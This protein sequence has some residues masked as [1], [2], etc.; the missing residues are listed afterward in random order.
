LI[1]DTKAATWPT[2]KSDFTMPCP[3]DL[4]GV[5]KRERVCKLITDEN[6]VEKEESKI[7]VGQGDKAVE[8]NVVR[9]GK[10]WECDPPVGAAVTPTAEE[11]AEY[12]RDPNDG[13]SKQADN[14]IQLP[15][16]SLKKIIE[17]GG[18]DYLFKCRRNSDGT[19]SCDAKAYMPNDKV[20]K[21]TI[22]RCDKQT[23]PEQYVTN[24]IL[25]TEVDGAPWLTACEPI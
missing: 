21:D 17:E 6:S 3:S 23:V 9:T 22:M 18:G 11:I 25:P 10:A 15:A 24:P 14:A 19:N 12:C 16:E 1:P 13:L 4:D 8:N 20:P 7:I 2:V 5:V